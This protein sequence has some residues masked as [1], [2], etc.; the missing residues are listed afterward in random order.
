MDAGEQYQLPYLVACASRR[1]LE[2]T[3]QQPSSRNTI[4][5]HLP[6]RDHLW[7]KATH[8]LRIPSGAWSLEHAWSDFLV[9]PPPF[10]AD[11]QCL[12]PIHTTA[13]VGRWDTEWKRAVA[14][15]AA[16]T[17][18]PA[19]FGARILR[20]QTELKP[21]FVSAC[22]ATAFKG[23]NKDPI[24]QLYPRMHEHLLDSPA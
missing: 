19:S 2:K 18:H 8:R 22:I 3:I 21:A 11:H 10:P 15:L 9:K 14:S 16:V 4:S 17:T 20:L 23:K 24:A 1:Y 12:S 5:C 7:L 13:C 6:F